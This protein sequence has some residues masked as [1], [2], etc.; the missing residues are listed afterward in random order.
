MFIVI[1]YVYRFRSNYLAISRRR[2]GDYKLSRIH[3]TFILQ[4]ID[5]FYYGPNRG[6]DKIRCFGTYLNRT[7]KV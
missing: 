6:R 4:Y 1:F 3:L 7:S 2:R 5:E